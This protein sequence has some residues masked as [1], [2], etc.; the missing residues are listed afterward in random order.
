MPVVHAS[1]RQSS[2]AAPRLPAQPHCCHRACQQCG[3][4]LFFIVC[5]SCDSGTGASSVPPA[6]LTFSSNIRSFFSRGSR[7]HSPSEEGGGFDAPTPG[8]LP[9]THSLSHT[10]TRTRPAADPASLRPRQKTGSMHA[11]S[12]ELEEGEFEPDDE[13]DDDDGEEEVV[14]SVEDAADLEGYFLG[15]VPS[16]LPGS[17][18]SAGAGS[19]GGGGMGGGAAGPGGSPGRGGSGSGSGIGSGSWNAGSGSGTAYTSPVVSEE[20]EKS[21][22]SLTEARLMERDRNAAPIAASVNLVPFRPH[23]MPAG[24]LWKRGE[25]FKV[26][27]RVRCVGPAPM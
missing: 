7:A 20:R 6:P 21:G 10:T 23:S 8:P 11:V 22:L 14:F 25:H 27:V 16:D 26:S 24:F 9:L 19:G 5:P 15:E 12:V 1:V 17:R 13:P 18:A 4:W 2:R 3:L